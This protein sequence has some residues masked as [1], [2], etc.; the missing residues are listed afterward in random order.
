[1]AHI[2]ILKKIS[3]AMLLCSLL[4][5][6]CDKYL[7]VE[8]KG[9]TLLK[10][11]ADYDQWLNDPK[12]FMFGPATT[13]LKMSDIYDFA[14]VALP[15]S[16]QTYIWSAQYSDGSSDVWGV[17][18]NNISSFNSV[19]VGIGSATGGTEQQKRNLKA[20]ALLGSAFEYFYLVNE[21]GK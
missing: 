1:M 12:L 6:A 14:N 11:V 15:P 4:L 9:Y 19:I 20:Q 18:Y 17:H 3:V 13:F 8:P 5:T 21:Y 16:A 2:H 7:D 10:T